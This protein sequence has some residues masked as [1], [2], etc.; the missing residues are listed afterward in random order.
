MTPITLNDG[1]ASALSDILKSAASGTRHLL[2]GHAGTG[3]T[4][5]MQAVV[6]E[7]KKRGGGVAV[8]APTHKAVQVIGRKMRDADI[9]VES[10]T[11]HS[12]LGLKVSPEGE[13]SVLKRGGNSQ[14][15]FYKFVIIDE[16]SMVGADLMG[17]IENDLR[18]HWVLF[19][20]D[21]AQ[22]PPVEETASK[23]FDVESRSVLTEIV[24]QEATN[25]I[26]AKA[27]ALREQQGSKVDWSWC[28]PA[29]GGHAGVFLAGD[30]PFPWMKDAFTSD[31]FGADND[32]FRFLA[33]T[34]ERVRAVNATVRSWIYGET[35]TP[36]VTGE[37]VICR[38]PIMSALGWVA[39]VTNE[40]AT[41]TSIEA[42]VK[43]YLFPEHEALG[44]RPKLPEWS[45]SIPIWRVSLAHP[46]GDVACDVPQ[47]QDDI[48]DIDR[49]LVSEA[50]ANHKRWFDRF[51]W[52]ETIADLRH[53]YALTVHSSQGSTFD[54]CFVD[55]RDCSKL[56]R[57]KPLEMQ[58][59]LYV[60][61]TRPRHALV[62]VGV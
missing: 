6:C 14:T 2:T 23:A 9:Y 46:S 13:R 40:E 41:V 5:L 30:D 27:T 20:G 28:T 57:S 55:I 62:L 45:K 29:D 35:E 17:F 51:S 50:K 8:T 60:A 39:F 54:N 38:Q 18:F 3:K 56:E 34:N 48:R 49:L 11:I 12:L 4:F 25:P 52:K 16:C 21:P 37:R 7:L 19:V 26:L 58:Q 59:L 61:V 24:R 32:A 15:A 44:S 36:F 10:M 42:E 1:Q 31:E 22:L 33:Y 43:T 53:V 47:R